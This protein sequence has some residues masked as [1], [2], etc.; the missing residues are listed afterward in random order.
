MTREK[1]MQF[2]AMQVAYLKTV[3]DND[4]SAQRDMIEEI[5]LWIEKEIQTSVAMAMNTLGVDLLRQYPLPQLTDEQ[6]NKFINMQVVLLT[7]AT[8]EKVNVYGMNEMEN[9]MRLWIDM[10]C[11]EA[12]GRATGTA[13]KNNKNLQPKF[14]IEKGGTN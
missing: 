12:T 10:Q 4:T 3:Q 7:L 13:L 2:A 5:L 1:A 6:R 8:A 11:D 9:E 14:K